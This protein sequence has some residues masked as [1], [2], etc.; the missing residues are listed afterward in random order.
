MSRGAASNRN[1]FNGGSGSM[2]SAPILGLSPRSVNVSPRGS[3][4]GPKT[5]G[6]FPGSSPRGS[7]TGPKTGGMMFDTPASTP[8][9]T[10]APTPGLIQSDSY[11]DE[12]ASRGSFNGN[13]TGGYFCTPIVP[14]V[15]SEKSTTI[16]DLIEE[17][18]GEKREGWEDKRKTRNGSFI[19]NNSNLNDN[20]LNHNVVNNSI[21]K[22]FNT[23][24]S[25]INDGNSENSDNQIRDNVSRGSSLNNSIGNMTSRSDKSIFEKTPLK[26]KK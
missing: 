10:P 1:S 4:T 20:Y 25:I 6:M 24:V 19:L 22:I 26:S 14:L 17:R 2:G 8:G 15:L 3:Y 13:L 16:A 5:G 11:R 21:M 18:R 12:P 7:F 9:L 23:D